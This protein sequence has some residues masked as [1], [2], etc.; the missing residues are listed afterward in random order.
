MSIQESGIH[1]ALP[2]CTQR[3]RRRSLSTR[4]RV[5][6][7]LEISIWGRKKRRK[8]QATEAEYQQQSNEVLP[9][10]HFKQNDYKHSDIQELFNTTVGHTYRSSQRGHLRTCCYDRQFWQS[11]QDLSLPHLI[12]F[13]SFAAYENYFSSFNFYVFSFVSV[14]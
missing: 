2:T 12:S 5:S 6:V 8:S 13:V 3:L 11:P 4:S 14:L 9:H 10:A 7:E 1:A